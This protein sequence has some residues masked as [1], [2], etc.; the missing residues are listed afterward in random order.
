MSMLFFILA[1]LVSMSLFVEYK[2]YTNGKPRLGLILL[3]IGC[4]V[5]LITQ[6]YAFLNK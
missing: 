1:I 6:I 2:N 3:L 5:I 4:E